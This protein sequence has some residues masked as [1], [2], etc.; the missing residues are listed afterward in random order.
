MENIR[1]WSMLI[2][3]ILFFLV[4]FYSAYLWV[5]VAFGHTQCLSFSLSLSF[6][7]SLSHTHTHTHTVGWN[8]LDEGSVR[9]GN[10]NLTIHHS[11]ETKS[12]APGEIRARSPT[13]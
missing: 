1:F 2:A 3:L 13:K 12:H 5:I 9:R 6:F 4:F 11:E 10:F 7:L 8:P